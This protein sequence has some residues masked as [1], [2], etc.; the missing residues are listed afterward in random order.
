MTEE[1]SKR[2]SRTVR[3]G[4]VVCA[5][6]G[7]TGAVAL[8][9]EWVGAAAPVESATSEKAVWYC[10]MHTHVTSHHDG[11]CPIC[12]MKLVKK[13]AAEPSGA[14]TFHVAPDTQARTGV[15]IETVQPTFFRPGI[16]VNAQVLADERRVVRLSP[17]VEGWIERL[18]VSVVGQPVK[19]GQVLFELYSPELQQRQ[20]D[21]VDLLTRRDALLAAKGGEMGLPVGNAVPDAMLASVARERFRMRA[22][23]EAADVPEHVLEEIERYRRPFDVVPVLARHDG[24][25]TDIGAREGAYVR[26]EQ[27]VVSYADRRAAWAELS[28]NPEMLERLASV[29]S[30]EIRSLADPE[31]AL[32]LP[33]DPNTAVIDPS[34]RTA[35]IR[36]PLAECGNDFLPGM[37]LDATVRTKAR[38]AIVVRSDTVIRTGRSDFIIVA[39]D[40]DHFRP[41]AVRIGAESDGSVEVLEGLE[42]GDRIVTNGQFLMSAESS[43]QSSMRRLT[44]SN[45]Q[46][47]EHASHRE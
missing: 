18:G 32:S 41:A 29:D 35:R 4:L 9:Y 46:Q 26:P 2:A 25:I 19:K 10:P 20:K 17:R 33:L 34:S 27:T 39:E 38:N 44:A 22:R 16:R 47:H 8:T 7:L 36:I 12:G 13:T 28:M 3:V 43:L 45:E 6:L 24:V 31:L 11:T 42:T 1:M 15:S 14:D 30:V 21:Y 40:N 23:L 5:L 37:L